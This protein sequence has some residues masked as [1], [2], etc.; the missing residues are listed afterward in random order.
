M[1]PLKK[2]LPP[3]VV[4][5]FIG[6]AAG[7][8]IAMAIGV[9]GQLLHPGDPSAGSGSIIVMITAPLGFFFGIIRYGSRR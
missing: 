4:G 3:V 9:L 2:P 8:A 1:N 5:A 7:V 6:T